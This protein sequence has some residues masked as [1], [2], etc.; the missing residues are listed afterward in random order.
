MRT[1]FSTKL[2]S[3]AFWNKN[4]SE[5]FECFT[6]DAFSNKTASRR[7]WNKFAIRRSSIRNR[8]QTRSIQFIKNEKKYFSSSQVWSESPSISSS[9]GLYLTVGERTI[10]VLANRWIW[11]DRNEIRTCEL[12]IK[13]RVYVPCSHTWPQLLSDGIRSL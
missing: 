9:D 6:G 8:V 7:V 11:N 4:A 5:R 12:M 13:K 3:N 1:R 2:R 10:S